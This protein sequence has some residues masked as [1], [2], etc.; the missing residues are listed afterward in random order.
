MLPLQSGC[1][2]SLSDYNFVL[3][4]TSTVYF[5][6]TSHAY[7]FITL[8][9]QLHTLSFIQRNLAIKLS[10]EYSLLVS[11]RMPIPGHTLGTHSACQEKHR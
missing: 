6:F 9:H 8:S 7:Y 10:G 1:R 3:L 4:A 11:M 5:M 2:M